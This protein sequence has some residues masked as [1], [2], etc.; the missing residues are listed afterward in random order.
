MVFIYGAIS[1]SCHS[2]FIIPFKKMSPNYEKVEGHRVGSFNFIDTR[3]FAYLKEKEKDGNIYLRC[4]FSKRC[5]LQTSCE[6]RAIISI[7]NDQLN[8]TKEHSCS[9]NDVDMQVLKAKNEM[10]KAAASTQTTFSIL[11]REA[12]ENAAPQVREKIPMA[13]VLSSLKAARRRT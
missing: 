6:G 9:P 3:G 7:E 5:D 10:K 2:H 12:L 8:V 11:H 1:K 13:K 4:K